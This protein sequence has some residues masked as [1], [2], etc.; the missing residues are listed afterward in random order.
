MESL[1][2]TYALE[3]VATGEV[4]ARHVK[5][6]R[7]PWLRALG[8]LARTSV[9]ADEGIWF[10]DCSAIHTIGMRASLE[11]I[12]LDRE[13][14]VIAVMPCVLPNRVWLSWPN[15]RTVVELG[16]SQGRHVQVGQM[17]GL[18]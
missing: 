13:H 18:R 2:K 11:V 8:F 1:L 17:L 12:F 10:D 16:I 4:L 3:N 15:A 6:A 9:T 14:V 7:S 5:Q